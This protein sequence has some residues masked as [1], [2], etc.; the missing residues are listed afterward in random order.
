MLK[1][2]AFKTLPSTKRGHRLGETEKLVEQA[3]RIVTNVKSRQ[4][5]AQDAML[6]TLE[7]MIIDKNLLEHK[8]LLFLMEPGQIEKNIAGL[9]ANKMMAKYQRPTCILTKTIEEDGINSF[10]SKT[11]DSFY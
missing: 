2:E 8:V 1:Y 10:Y 7:Q 6:D 3:M 4:T 5:K 11:F 9:C